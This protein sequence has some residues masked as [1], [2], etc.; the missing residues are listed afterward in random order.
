MLVIPRDSA[1][2]SFYNGTDLVPL[3]EQDTYKEDWIGLK[4]LDE[5]GGLV[6]VHCPTEHMGFT[7]QWFTDNIMEPYLLPKKDNV[8]M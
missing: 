2:F 3:K 4:T 6:F 1:W 5:N 8:V 7:M